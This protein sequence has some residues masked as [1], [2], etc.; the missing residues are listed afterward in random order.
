[1]AE[2]HKAGNNITIRGGREPLFGIVRGPLY[3]HMGIKADVFMPQVHQLG[4]N[5]GR[6][7]FVWDQIEPERG[8]FVWEAIDTLL[9]QLEPSDEA[10]I[11]L[12]ASS[13]WAT[14]HA[15]NFQPPSPALHPEDYYRFVSTLVSHCKGRVR[16]WQCEN[17]PTNP[18]LWEGTPQDYSNQLKIFSQAVKEADPE[19]VV[20]L[21]GAVDAFHEAAGAHNPDTQSERD[22]FDYLLRENATDFDVFDL[23]T[24]GD[25][26]AIR[27][28]IDAVRQKMATFGYQK[29][30]FIGEYNGPS[31][32]YFPENLSIMQSLFERMLSNPTTD[33]LEQATQGT[34]IADLYARMDT[35]PP[36]AQMFMDGCSPELEQKRH[37][38][39]CRELVMRSLLALSADVQKMFC[40]N[41]ANEKVDRNNMMHLLFDKHKL[42]DYE[43]GVFKQPY[44]AAETFSLITSELKDMKRVQQ[45]ELP[46]QPAIYLFEV[47]R[48]ER[49]PLYVIWERHDT[50]SGEDDPVTPFS[51]P[52]SAPQAWAM[53]V[54]GQTIPTRVSNGHLHLSL[55]LTPIFIEPQAEN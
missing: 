35:L 50:F 5:M 24:Y 1:M 39:N 51:Y 31:F 45:L 22:F 6:L 12:N 9:E 53:D 19:A 33:T 23:H 47:Q 25:P 38:I 29:P 15:T 34:A 41:L 52:W 2:Y 26:Y 49:G 21:A 36:Q 11:T 32:F 28:N 40:W 17:E 54:F 30:V 27:P 48:R 20:I 43:A 10:W 55:S 42:F 14:R 8:H 13:L 37:R 44:P 3:G 7:F 4:A 46:E 18:M 16:Y